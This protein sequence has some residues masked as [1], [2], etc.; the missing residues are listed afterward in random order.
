MNVLF[1]GVGYFPQLTS[2]EKNFFF[3]LFPLLHQQ[4]NIAVFSLN[5]YHESLLTQETPRGQIPIYCARRPFHQNYEKFF[6]QG[7]G[8]TS[9]RHHHTPKQEILEKFI[10]IVFHLPKLRRIVRKHEI[11]IIHFMDNFGPAMPLVR[12]AFRDVY[13]TYS[14]ACYDPRGSQATYDRYLK[15][16]LGHLDA[17][18]V[19]TEAYAQRLREIGVNTPYQLTPWGVPIDE[20]PLSEDSQLDIRRTLGIKK[21]HKFVL[22]SGYL[23]QIQETDFYKTI[24]VARDVTG[25]CPNLNFVFAFKPETFQ[26]K[27]AEESDNQIKIISGVKNFKAALE[28]ADLFCS[29]IS[30]QLSTVSPPLTWLEAMSKG[31]PIIT[32]KIKGVSEVIKHGVTGFVSSSYS[33]L[34]NL[35]I[36]VSEEETLRRVGEEAKLFIQEHY[37]IQNSAQRYVRF[38]ETLLSHEERN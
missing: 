16:S 28:S 11:N 7:N 4:V 15:L 26:E 36:S 30:N 27:Y 10:S 12:Q 34:A 2:G 8:Y 35:L 37:S 22:W 38:Y 14:A 18:G 20:P 25:K 5:D 6:Y 31:T 21:E 3:R 32:T 13:V 1:I 24:E 17:L 29:P 9:Y 33:E 19:Y 23:Q